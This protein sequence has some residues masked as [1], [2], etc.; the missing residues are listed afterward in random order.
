[1]YN[2]EIKLLIDT[3]EAKADYKSSAVVE[4]I[5]SYAD[6]IITCTNTPKFS[7]LYLLILNLGFPCFGPTEYWSH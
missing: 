4:I 6:G 1:L 3:K 2:D 7:P 5:K